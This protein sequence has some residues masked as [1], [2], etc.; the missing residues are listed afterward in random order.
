MPPQSKPKPD[1]TKPDLTKP[2]PTKP[3]PTKPDLTKPDPTNTK[4]DPTKPDPHAGVTNAFA[5][6]K[7]YFS[8]DKD[9]PNHFIDPKVQIL[10][11]FLNNWEKKDLLPIIEDKAEQHRLEIEKEFDAYKKKKEAEIEKLNAEIKKIKE[12]AEAKLLR[13][14]NALIADH[15]KTMAA[16]IVRFIAGED[17]ESWE[18][19]K[20]PGLANATK[21]T[22]FTIKLDEKLAG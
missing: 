10:R 2:D 1:F 3:D 7:N 22:K 4:P 14:A 16:I 11:D 9:T 12:E 6:H 19:L 5:A 17:A 13:T 18:S 8:K 20:L 21:P 15:N